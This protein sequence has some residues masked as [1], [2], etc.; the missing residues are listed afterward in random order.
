MVFQDTI[1]LTPQEKGATNITE[2]ITNVIQDSKI[3]TG[4]CQLFVDN[5]HSI[6][7]INDTADEN[8]KKKT[9]AFLAQLAP[10]SHGTCKTIEKNMDEIPEVT[11]VT[12]SQTSVSFPINRGRPL[13]GTWQ[14]IYLWESTSQPE[15]RNLTITIIGD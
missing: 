11:R 8:T 2:L 5:S 6:L 14:G 1:K 15:T 4:I 3:S 13:L 7:L 10:S 9:A 12:L